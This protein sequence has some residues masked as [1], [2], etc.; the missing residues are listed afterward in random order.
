MRDEAGPEACEGSLREPAGRRRR[1]AVP[2]G[3]TSGRGPGNEDA[4]E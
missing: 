2:E 1:G 4:H 3:G